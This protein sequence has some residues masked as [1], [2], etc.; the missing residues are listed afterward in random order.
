MTATVDDLVQ[1]TARLRSDL[2]AFEQRIKDLTEA[3]DLL[4]RSLLTS[5]DES[6]VL[7]VIDNLSD[8]RLDL[9]TADRHL[10]AAV[11]HVERL[12]LA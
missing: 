6:V 12:S 1:S 3:F 8:A 7:E 9:T 10:E 11:R 5:S 2:N 4:D